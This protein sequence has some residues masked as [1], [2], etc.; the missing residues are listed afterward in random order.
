MQFSQ[1][2]RT[3]S[4]LMASKG[5]SF[6]QT[7][8]AA[9]AGERKNPT[10]ITVATCGSHPVT[11]GRKSKVGMSNAT[12]GATRA[13]GE[14]AYAGP[15]MYA[16]ASGWFACCGWGTYRQIETGAGFKIKIKQSILGCIKANLCE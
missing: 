14:R 13:R 4:K 2:K 5:A 1:M 3:L 9:G 6:F 15:R 10:V 16:G 8:M 12:T 11:S 7:L